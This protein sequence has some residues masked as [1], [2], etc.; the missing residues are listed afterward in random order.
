MQNSF[1]IRCFLL[2]LLFSIGLLTSPMLVAQEDPVDV[3]LVIDVSGSMKQNDPNNLRQPAVG[4]LVELLPENSKAGVWTFGKWVNMLIPHKPV[5]KNWRKSA[6]RESS[7][8]NS[9]GLFTNIGEALEKA[10]Y[11]QG[12]VDQSTKKHII[13]LTDGMVDID[14]ESAENKEEWRRIAD[15]VLPKLRS[16]GYVI[17]T[18]ALSKNADRDLMN[19]LSV[20]TDGMAD[21]AH[22]ADDLMKIF[23]KAFDAAV[24]SEQVALNDNTFVVDSSVEEFT[25][26]F[27][28]S[29]PSEQTQI[30]TPDEKVWDASTSDEELRWHRT[31]YYDLVTVKRPL[32]GSWSVLGE[33]DPQSRVT[34]V[35]NLNVR[36]RPLPNNVLKGS[37]LNLDV[38]LQEDG[39]TI[40]NPDF[41][42]LMDVKAELFG[43]KKFDSLV[44]LWS[45][46]LASTST[47]EGRY[48][49]GLPPLDKE[50]VYEVR[51][52]VD[53][54]TFT[55]AIKHQITLRQ[56]FGAEVREQF[57]GGLLNYVLTVNAFKNE[58]DY[59]STQV[60]ASITKPTGQKIVRPIPL[61]ELDTW[62]T[63]L[64]PSAE[65]TYKA[66]IQVKGSL[67]DGTEFK[68]DLDE[69]SFNYSVANGMVAEERAFIEEKEEPVKE[70]PAEPEVPE[71]TAPQEEAPTI[72][73]S[74]ALPSWVLYAALGVGNLLLLGLGYFAF[75]KIM[76]GP[77]KDILEELEE[78]AEEEKDEPDSGE[79]AAAAETEEEEDEEEPPMEDLD[80][81][82]SAEDEAFEEPVQAESPAAEEPV[83]NE[84]LIEPAEEPPELLEPELLEPELLEPE[85]EPD[86]E[87]IP[88]LEP[89]DVVSPEE[90]QVAPE[91]IPEAIDLDG[92]DDLDAMALSLDEDAT[93]DTG[94]ANE[95]TEEDDDMVEAMLKAQG[96][97]LAEEELDDAISSL[98][99]DLE[100]DDDKK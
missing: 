36:M 26:L 28:R 18:I 64:L 44:S 25:A 72:E 86:D 73:E 22:T 3:R 40:T 80:P 12:Y 94:E 43:G 90:L 6:V 47:L 19:K 45:Y 9:V 11:D 1:Y 49:G 50:G 57:E 32:E 92:I 33:L 71:E 84:E 24:P 13:L 89:D 100:E 91:E 51:V 15:E 75:R 78:E 52:T 93:E 10:A 87:D 83:E 5:D 42:S 17:H 55:R 58:V 20:G 69:L 7:K 85:Q 63:K 34:V 2:K 38:F 96:L 79:S 53:G 23:L 99:D 27:F 41:L 98:I 70:P 66:N 30:I 65:G 74:S 31:E 76:G 29:N 46:E 14:K 21:I 4:L 62:Q 54:K 61:S 77:K 35:S 59:S 60:V 37:E 56:A 95:A 67:T 8:I 82:S 16:S 68:Y 39:K 88:T 97:D 81:D 48:I